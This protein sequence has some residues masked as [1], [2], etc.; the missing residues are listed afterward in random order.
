MGFPRSGAAGRVLLALM[1][2][3]PAP[4]LAQ[5]PRQ[6]E[7]VA[8]IPAGPFQIYPSFVADVAHTDNL[9]YS[10]I[11]PVRATTTTL[12]PGVFVQLPMRQNEVHFGYNLRYRDYG[13]AD[14]D[15]LVE[16][17]GQEI[18]NFSHFFVAAGEFQLASGLSLDFEDDYAQG[19]LDSS[20]FDEGG[21]VVFRGVD[22]TSNY[23]TVA[24]GH[25]TGARRQ[26]GVAVESDIVEFQP[27][28]NSGG[29]FD[30]DYLRFDLSVRQ[31]FGSQAT[32]SFGAYL[33]EGE[34]TRVNNPADRRDERTL[35]LTVRMQ[36]KLSPSSN[37]EGEFGWGQSDY[38]STDGTTDQ[39]R[40]LVYSINYVRV[41]PARARLTA[42]VSQFV[43][44]SIFGSNFYYVSRQLAFRMENSTAARLNFGGAVRYYQ[45][46]YPQG[47]PPRTDEVLGGQVWVGYRFGSL[48]VGRLFADLQSRTSIVSQLD[49]DVTSIG[50]SVG[51][52]R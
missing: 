14:V 33:L 23:A 24:L 22:F 31:Q 11:D 1:F 26:L 4:A 42:R 38:S 2:L 15:E 30:S 16:R 47:L 49:Y 7:G 32:M 18:D 45:N 3:S 36:R 13:G 48:V 9:F 29:L 19:V 41:V 40:N 20:A 46:E 44:N 50:F 43:Y 27:G 8:P 12:L 37:I 39:N 5:T 6:P 35:R 51:L 21:E 25:Q 10:G 17:T 28:L 52:G 34:S